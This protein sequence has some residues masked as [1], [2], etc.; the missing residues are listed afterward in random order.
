MSPSLNELGDDFSP[1]AMAEE[2]GRF[3]AGSLLH[4]QAP[5][6]LPFWFA[7]LYQPYCRLHFL[8][9]CSLYHLWENTRF[10]LMA[11]RQPM[12][13]KPSKW[14]AAPTRVQPSRRAR[15]KNRNDYSE[16][17]AGSRTSSPAA[18]NKQKDSWSVLEARRKQLQHHLPWP[19]YK[20]RLE[21]QLT[22]ISERLYYH[23]KEDS[24]QL[25]PSCLLS[26]IAWRPECR[27]CTFKPEV[28]DSGC[29]TVRKLAQP[30]PMASIYDDCMQEE[31]MGE[32]G[33]L[34]FAVD[35]CGEQETIILL[36]IEQLDFTSERVTGGGV[37]SRGDTVDRT[38]IRMKS[39]A[40]HGRRQE[41]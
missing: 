3:S 27:Y 2:G 29:S 24:S 5:D 8:R 6:I 41:G 25:H 19:V 16:K 23:R 30:A 34:K 22:Q 17:A 35:I 15:E 1:I 11:D 7:A 18:G 37:A 9:E 14:P 39:V 36:G 4:Q 40:G 28:V 31:Q 20:A 33:G 10:K 26:Y 13:R 21:G 38:S 32:F 12:P